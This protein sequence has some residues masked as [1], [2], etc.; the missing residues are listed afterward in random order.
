[1]IKDLDNMLE[2][3]KNVR[4]NAYSP[5]SNYKVGACIKSNKTKK[6]YSGCNVENASYGA[7]ICAER[8]AITTMV[9][10]EGKS[11]LD[12]VVIVTDEKNPAPPCALCL[13]VL[14][15][16]CNDDTNIILSN[17]DDNIIKYK[18][19]NLLP[20]PFTSFKI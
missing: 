7:T 17:L 14:A 18:F 5:Y 19:K 12:A 13:Q 3:A 20:H 11:L 4:N 10:S 1:M 16:F 6:L 8:N 15:E 9:S 2:I